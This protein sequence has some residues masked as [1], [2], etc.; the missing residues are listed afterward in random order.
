MWDTCTIWTELF[1]A[2]KKEKKIAHYSDVFR[3]IRC[4]S[5]VP[6]LL[7]LAHFIQSRAQLHLAVGVSGGC[8]IAV[9]P[10]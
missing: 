8:T 2:I 9:P 10:L 3:S 6:E 1:V 4:V 7:L 5:H